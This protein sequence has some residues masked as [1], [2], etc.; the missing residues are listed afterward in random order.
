MRLLTCVARSSIF[1]LLAGCRSGPVGTEYEI[2]SVAGTLRGATGA[3]IGDGRIAVAFRDSTCAP[4][5]ESDYQERPTTSTGSFNVPKVYFVR[6]AICA[7]VR[8]RSLSMSDSVV[9]DS[10]RLGSFHSTLP[11][12]VEL[13]LQLP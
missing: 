13:E 5:S 7:R 11:N 12:R 3:P 1:A 6:T 10:V 9:V 4:A 2:V 8:G